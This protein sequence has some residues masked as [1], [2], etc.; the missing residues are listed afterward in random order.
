[1]AEAGEL[2]PGESPAAPGTLLDHDGEA[3]RIAC[4]PEGRELL[5]VTR[6][7]LPGGKA[8][9]VG[10]LLRARGDRFLPGLRLGHQDEETPA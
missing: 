5:R 1:M 9:P 7:Q 4:G 6:A 8:L 3:L 2:A 10:E